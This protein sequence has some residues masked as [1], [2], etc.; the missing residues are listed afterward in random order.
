M[1]LEGQASSAE[2]PEDR[3]QRRQPLGAQNHVITCK[4]H[5]KQIDEENITMDSDR[6]LTYDAHAR[7][8]ITVRHRSCEAGSV[9]E[10]QPGALRRGLGDEI[11]S[12]PGVQERDEGVA[13][14]VDV[15]PHG[16]GGP[17]ACNS[18]Q[19]EGRRLLC[20]GQFHPCCHFVDVLF[21]GAVEEEQP[22][23]DAVMPPTK[24]LIAVVA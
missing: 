19:G 1:P 9:L 12:R 13:G 16:A 14:E 23:T 2:I 6:R 7:H 24:L 18:V 4:R 20:L 22:L 17:D 11:V 8:P 15:D 5:N 10:G 3:A 21:H